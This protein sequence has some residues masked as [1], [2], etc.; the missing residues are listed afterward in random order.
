MFIFSVLMRFARES[1]C[2]LCGLWY[3]HISAKNE[4]GL[5]HGRSGRNIFIE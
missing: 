1:L 5:G 4:T 3:D 2:G